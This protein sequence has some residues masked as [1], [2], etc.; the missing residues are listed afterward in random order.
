M[1]IL[2]CERVAAP[3]KNL[4]LPY[5]FFNPVAPVGWVNVDVGAGDGVLPPPECSLTREHERVKTFVVQN[6]KFQKTR[7]GRA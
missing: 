1:A 6:G 5:P 3:H 2:V 7:K 4:V